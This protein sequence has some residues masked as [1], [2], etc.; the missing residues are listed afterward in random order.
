MKKA[1]PKE[2]CRPTSNT[3][4]AP[5]APTKKVFLG[6]M[7]LDITKEEF[8]E[9]M[10]QYGKLIDSQ[11]MTDKVTDEPRGF[12]FV[13]F[14]DFETAAAVCALKYIKLKVSR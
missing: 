5:A 7:P 2:D 10:G 8:R 14:Q 3:P 4:S 9:A 13:I 11:I 6:G 12:A 1:I